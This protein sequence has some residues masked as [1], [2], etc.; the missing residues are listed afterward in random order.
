MEINSR[1]VLRR[2]LPEARIIGSSSAVLP[3]E[4]GLVFGVYIQRLRD[5]SNYTRITR[6]VK[7]ALAMY[8]PQMRLSE[9]IYRGQFDIWQNEELMTSLDHMKK[10]IQDYILRTGSCKQCS[11][12][13]HAYFERYPNMNSLY[14]VAAAHYLDKGCRLPQF[15]GSLC[16]E[17]R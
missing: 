3:L 15:S 12:K 10:D 4:K 11:E 13:S 8:E 17:R 14:E 5:Q 2:I 1:Q 16:R 6:Y 7:F 9:P